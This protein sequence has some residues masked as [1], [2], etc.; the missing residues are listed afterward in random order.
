MQNILK[1]TKSEIYLWSYLMHKKKL[2]KN[3]KEKECLV[4][5]PLMNARSP[6]YLAAS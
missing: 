2:K 3:L 6:T 4:S 5:N 1:K